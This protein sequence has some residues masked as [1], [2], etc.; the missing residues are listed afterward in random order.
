MKKLMEWGRAV[1]MRFLN[2]VVILLLVAIAGVFVIVDGVVLTNVVNQLQTG[3]YLDATFGVQVVFLFATLTA[4][5]ITFKEY[6]SRY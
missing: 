4:F 3:M 5:V 6:V 2:L 1:L